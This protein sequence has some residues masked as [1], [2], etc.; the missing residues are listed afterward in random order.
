VNSRVIDGLRVLIFFMLAGLLLAQVVVLPNEAALA[1]RM[2]PEVAG[3]RWPLLTLAILGV[4]AVQVVLVLIMRL[5]TLVEDGKVFSPA[6]FGFVDGI[7][8]AAVA[9]VAIAVMATVVLFAG[10]AG[11]P[12]PLLVLVAT[13]MFAGGIALLMAVMR[14]LLVRA[15]ALDAETLALHAELEGVI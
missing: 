1:A 6:A 7:I 3:L 12:G 4:G 13:G 14:A 9:G 10:G 5:L 11:H 15:V 8:R 2:H